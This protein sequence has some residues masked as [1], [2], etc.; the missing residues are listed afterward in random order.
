MAKPI[1]TVEL[2]YTLIM[3]FLIIAYMRVYYL[4][5]GDK[6]TSSAL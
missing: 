3:P 6:C 1:K 5:F 4:A 2:H